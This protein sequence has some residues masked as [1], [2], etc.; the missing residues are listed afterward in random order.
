ML[1]FEKQYYNK[2]VKLIAGTD[3]AG[4]GCLLGPVV[5]A[6]VIF[7]SDFFDERINDSKKLSEKKRE[8]LFDFI[9]EHAISY[10]IC[11]ISPDEIDEINILEASRKAMETCIQKLNVKPDFVLTD[12]VKLYHCHCGFDAIIKGDAKAQ[13]IAAASILA[14]VTRDRICLQLDKKYPEYNIKSN[15]G[16]GTKDHLEALEKYGPKKGLHRFSYKPVKNSMIQ[17]VSLFDL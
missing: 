13:C 16:Y 5:A 14:K 15:K 4:R 1:D 2:E 11:E 6:A 9:I 8:E 10:S 17:K 7:P 3:E 12:A